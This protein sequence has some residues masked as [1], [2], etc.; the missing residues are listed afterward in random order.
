MSLDEYRNITAERLHRFMEVDPVPDAEIMESPLKSAA[1]VTGLGAYDW[2]L[3]AKK[4]LLREFFIMSISGAGTERHRGL[5][6]NSIK[7][8]IGG[9]FCLTEI[10]HGTN[11]KGLG[12][13]ATYDKD[14][15]SFILH[16]PSFEA[17][18]C[19]AG[20]L[21]KSATHSSVFAQLYTPDGSCHGLHNFLVP[22]RDPVSLTPY[23]G[24]IIGDMG[25]KVGLN[26]LDN[27]WMKFNNYSIP[28]ESLMN[29]TGDVTAEGN[30]VSPY[31]DP[32]KRFGASLGNLSGGRVGI[33]N[34]AN[35]NLHLSVV[36]AVRYS[37]VSL[38]PEK[39]RSGRFYSIKHSTDV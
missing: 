2:S 12:T 1:L 36:I 25:S 26:G 6:K 39:G 15:Q 14:T 30:Y 10:S 4:M 28:R 13:S 24:V 17:A 20:N 3:A 33:I 23:P 34:M 37:A 7:N 5:L 38:D 11:T 35:T 8:R 22:V 19:W 9:S 21:A 32:N 29:K 27:G 31:K 18:K 16:S